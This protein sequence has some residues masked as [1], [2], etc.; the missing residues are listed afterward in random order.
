[1]PTERAAG[2][3]YRLPTEAEW[4]HAC[5]AGTTTRYN[6]GPRLHPGEATF[7]RHD[8]LASWE[9]IAGTADRVRLYALA[10]ELEV[11]WQRLVAV[12][13]ELGIAAGNQ[14][15]PLSLA[16]TERVVRHH[17][18]EHSLPLLPTPGA[19]FPAEVIR[20]GPV[21]EYAPNAFGLFD[22][23][24][25]VGEWCADWY[26]VDYYAVSPTTNPAG[27]PT[28]TQRVVRGGSWRVDGYH[29]RS[30]SRNKCDPNDSDD[31]VGVRPVCTI[32]VPGEPAGPTRGPS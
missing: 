7:F 14:V 6:T 19:Y 3:R 31:T 8:P 13:R 9:R 26:D 2:R 11:D 25:N 5:R 32:S 24:G 1:M 27:P 28:G 20:T 21:G 23:H 29:C 16:D 10:R 12:C 4:E 17:L 15:A 18:R 30:A 22:M